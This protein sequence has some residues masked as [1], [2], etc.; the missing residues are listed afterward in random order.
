VYAPIEPERLGMEGI[1]RSLG[2][3]LDAHLARGVEIR[4]HADGLV[5]RAE[6]VADIAARLDGIWSRFELIL[7]HMDIVQAQIA[8]AARRRSGHVAG[9]H[10]RSL[11]VM[12]HLIDERGMRG[13][14]LSQ[15]P[16]DG[17]WLLWHEA[18]DRQG[19]VLTLMTDDELEAGAAAASVARQ[20]LAT[21]VTGPRPERGRRMRRTD[22]W[23]PRAGTRSRESI[24]VQAGRSM[25]TRAGAVAEI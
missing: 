2:T 15:H 12:G 9:P 8:T 13:L 24:P 23:A 16:S 3:V 20:P 7:T 22:G 11:G 17:A 21:P 4:Q 25:L 18:D 14:T 10:E 1:L 6:A 19:L 5:I